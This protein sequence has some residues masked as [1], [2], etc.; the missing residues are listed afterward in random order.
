MSVNYQ[1]LVGTGR[2][3]P[4]RVLAIPV[5]PSLASRECELY[6]GLCYWCLYRRY[7]TKSLILPGRE[8]GQ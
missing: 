6:S 5:V 7:A 8:R 1:V 4:N 3:C 2:D